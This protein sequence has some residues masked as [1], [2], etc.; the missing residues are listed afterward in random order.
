MRSLIKKISA[1]A[2]AALMTAAVVSGGNIYAD[3]SE[4][5]GTSST[6]TSISISPVSEVLQLSPATIYDA[7]FKVSNNGDSPME[8]EVYAAPYAYIYSEDDDAYRLGFSRENNFTQITRWIT[9][10]DVS[11]NYVEKATF[12]ADPKSDVEV[13]YRITTPE[14]IPAG[15]QYAVLFAHTLSGSVNSSG[16]KTEAS[17]GLV[18]YGRASGDTIISSEISGVAINNTMLVD[19]EEKTIINAVGKIKNTGNV[20]FMAEGKLKV[21]GIFG[22]VYYETPAGSTAA[23]IS[24]IPDTELSVTDSWKDTPF[25]GMFNV[26]WTVTAN[27]ENPQTI[28]KFVVIMPPVIIIIILLLLTVII[29][30]IIIVLRKRK[31]RRSKFMV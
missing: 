13:S 17:P 18:V 29:M 28:T 6:A 20:D 12:T 23:R 8:F 5:A 30:W 19:G 22:N 1:L 11:G 14:S 25:F 2:L 15:G 7:V 3:E 27:D 9:F 21:T 26:E 10:K 31:E 24:V 16:I 4:N